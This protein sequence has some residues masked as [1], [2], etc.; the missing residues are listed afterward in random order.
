LPRGRA[1]R[2]GR[3][4]NGGSITISAGLLIPPA[5]PRLDGNHIGIDAI[6]IFI[7]Q[8]FVYQLFKRP[9]ITRQ[10]RARVLRRG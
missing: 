4:G 7:K 1:P 9:V 10:A 5:V 3:P 2:W 6:R 8:R